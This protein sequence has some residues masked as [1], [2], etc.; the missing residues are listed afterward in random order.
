MTGIS[1]PQESRLICLFDAKRHYLT[2]QLE[3][4]VDVTH[5]KVYFDW[6]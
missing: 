1:K 6:I 4:V 5:E 3:I 2:L